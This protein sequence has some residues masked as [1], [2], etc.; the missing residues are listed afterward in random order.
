MSSIFGFNRGLNVHNENDAVGEWQ[1]H[2]NPT[3]C[4]VVLLNPNPNGFCSD[5]FV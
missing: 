4:S 1:V 5:L 2:K 3:K